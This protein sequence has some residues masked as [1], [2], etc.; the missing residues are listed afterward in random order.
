MGEF[1]GPGIVA[2]V[3]VTHTDTPATAHSLANKLYDLRIFEHA[4][5]DREKI[6]IPPGSPRELSAAD[7]NLPVLVISQFT[8][9]ANTKKGRRP[10]WDAAAPRPQAAPLVD[11]FAHALRERG[12]PVS[13]GEFGADMSVNLTNDGPF[14]IVLDS[15]QL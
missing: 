10:T 15:D 2:L 14:T 13:T 6:C 9:Y 5:F 11:A 12:A 3:G 1:H 8:L 7:G 4:H